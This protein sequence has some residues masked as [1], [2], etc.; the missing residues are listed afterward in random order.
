VDADGIHDERFGETSFVARDGN[1]LRAL[2]YRSTGFDPARGPI[3]FVMHGVNRDADRYLRAAAPV[4]D[5]SSSLAGPLGRAIAA[6]ASRPR[7][8]L[9]VALAITAGAAVFAVQVP[10]EFDVEDFFSSDSD[11][12]V[13]LDLVDAHVGERG[14]EPAQVYIEADLEDPESLVALAGTVERIRTLDTDVLA[15]S[16]PRHYLADSLQLS[17]YFKTVPRLAPEPGVRAR[18]AMGTMGR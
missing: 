6:V 10:A 15:E 9:P 16:A 7:V 8:V 4:A 2:T 14:G 1:R 17:G 18:A 3:W 5:S 12:V 13:A 11:F